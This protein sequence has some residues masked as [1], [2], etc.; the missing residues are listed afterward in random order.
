MR[1]TQDTR[2][3][4]GKG[5]LRLWRQIYACDCLCRIKLMPG[6]L[7]PKMSND[8]KKSSRNGAAQAESGA[9]FLAFFGIGAETSGLGNLELAQAKAG[10]RVG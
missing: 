7:G 4:G 8:C 6:T 2:V 1:I 3:E 10:S 9:A 5:I